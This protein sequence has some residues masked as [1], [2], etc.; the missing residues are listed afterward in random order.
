MKLTCRDQTET[1]PTC[2]SKSAQQQ[3]IT[4]CAP[5]HAPHG[6]VNSQLH[7]NQQGQHQANLGGGGGAA[8]FLAFSNLV[9]LLTL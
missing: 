1:W 7:A 6:L 5:Y 4:L 3:Y 9:T 8:R 2:V